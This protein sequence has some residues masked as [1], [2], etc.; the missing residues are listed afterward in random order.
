MVASKG[1]TLVIGLGNPGRRYRRTRHNIGFRVV[2]EVARRHRVRLR[3]SYRMAARLAR[4]EYADR[5]VLL[6]EPQTYMNRSGLT[7]R[8]VMAEFDTGVEGLLV[9]VDDVNLPLGRLR[10]RQGG[11]D[12]GH[13]GLQSVVAALGSSEF[14]RVRVGVG[15][16]QARDLT[17]HVLGTFERPERALVA[18]VIG[19]AADAV[20]AVIGEGLGPAMNTFNGMDLAGQRP[21]GPVEG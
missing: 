7:V 12:G 6:V 19:T 16:A 21:P 2:E 17:E 9:V 4:I 10:V 13:H 8:A 5:A 20:H 11:G 15:G 18:T 1:V 14:A 3:R